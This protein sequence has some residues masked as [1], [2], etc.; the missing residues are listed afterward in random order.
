MSAKILKVE[1]ENYFQQVDYDII[2]LY[3]L[4]KMNI[5]CKAQI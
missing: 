5:G 4:V 2:R 1:A 3:W